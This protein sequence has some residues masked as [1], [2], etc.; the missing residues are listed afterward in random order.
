MFIGRPF[1]I[2]IDDLGWMKGRND[3]FNGQGPFRLG[4]K[5]NM[6]LQDYMTLVDLAQHA[7]VRLQA[8]FILGEMDQN[9]ALT[10]FDIGFPTVDDYDQDHVIKNSIISYVKKSSAHLEFGLHGVSHE[11]WPSGSKISKRAEWYNLEDNHPWPEEDIRAHLD[12]FQKIMDQYDINPAHGHSF[13]ESFVPCAYSYYWNPHPDDD[14]YCLGQILQEY[15][16][17]YANTDFSQ[18]PELSPPVDGGF[19]GP[20]HVMNRH[21]YGNLWYMLGT[22]PTMPLRYQ[23][24]DFIEAHWPNL[25]AQDEF[26]QEEVTSKWCNLFAQ[27]QKTGDRYLSKNTAQ[28]HSQFLYQKYTKLTQLSDQYFKIDNT[29]MPAEI[30]L[31]FEFQN[32]VCKIQQPENLHLNNICLNG[33]PIPAYYEEEGFVFL[34]LPPLDAQVYELTFEQSSSMPTE[35]MW[36]NS[37]SNILHLNVEEDYTQIEVIVYGHQVLIYRT[38][39]AIGQVVSNNHRLEIIAWKRMEDSIHIEVK[40]LNMQGEKGAISLIEEAN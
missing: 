6:C 35:I 39:K 10:S 29:G 22:T 8:L 38:E 5:R 19:D 17:K 18:I 32:L 16:V 31:K 12:C 2:A 26:L 9:N 27:V 21:N 14:Q 7:G 30:L 11:F 20:V 40:A 34:Y 24:T 15:G 23:T 3:G 28:H 36:H 25:I 13:P 37:T 33:K 1:A 4:V